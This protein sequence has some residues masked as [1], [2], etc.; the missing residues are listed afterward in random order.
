MPE[1]PAPSGIDAARVA[2]AAARAAAKQRPTGPARKKPAVARGARRGAGRDPISVM[3][4]IQQMLADRGYEVPAA[5]GSIIDQWPAIAPE[6]AGKV[7]AEAFD[8]DTGCLSLRPASA[9]YGVQMRLSQQQMVARI[10]E[11]AGSAV[12]RSLRILPPRTPGTDGPGTASPGGQPA[13]PRSGPAVKTRADA[14]PGLRAAHDLLAHLR[15]GAEQET[16]RTAPAA[17]V[18]VLREPEKAFADAIALTEDIPT[19]AA[20]A[21]DP[22]AQAIARARAEKAGR[23]PTAPHTLARTA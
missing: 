7:A 17:Y 18:P 2:L 1:Q 21:E 19:A 6:L 3:A 4:A 10:A 8:A 9:A 11:K 12:V 5:G 20:R 13:A 16:A 15:A 22:R 14:S 23:T